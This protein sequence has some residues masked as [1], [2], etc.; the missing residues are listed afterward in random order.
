MS[1][2]FGCC[3]WE[4]RSW[5]HQA[6]GAFTVVP[7]SSSQSGDRA[8]ARQLTPTVWEGSELVSVV[9][10]DDFTSKGKNPAESSRTGLS[11]DERGRWAGSQPGRFKSHFIGPVSRSSVSRTLL[12][13]LFD[14]H[15]EPVWRFVIGNPWL[16]AWLL[17][18]YFHDSFG[19]LKTVALFYFLSSTAFQTRENEALKWQIEAVKLQR[20]DSRARP[21]VRVR[22]WLRDK[23]FSFQIRREKIYSAP[24]QW[25]TGLRGVCFALNV[26]L[27]FYSHKNRLIVDAISRGRHVLCPCHSLFSHFSA[28]FLVSSR[29]TF[30]YWWGAR[31]DFLNSLPF[32]V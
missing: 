27:S 29:T 11:V 18:I 5:P 16:T 25:T 15:E 12:N 22:G 20:H 4:P 9:G 28:G 8:S 17:F 30:N 13:P 23:C 31:N 26:L 1:P 21:E 19:L 7:F 24:S 3:F 10:G 32:P 6:R 14:F 2:S